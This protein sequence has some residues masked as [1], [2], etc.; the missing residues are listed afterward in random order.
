MKEAVISSETSALKELHG[1]TA[2]KTPFFIV[3]S[4]KT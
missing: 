2:Q 1:V 4:V 3:I